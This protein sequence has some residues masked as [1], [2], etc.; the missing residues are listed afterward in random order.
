M[1]DLCFGKNY[2]GYRNE[3]VEVDV[4]EKIEDLFY[5]KD[6]INRVKKLICFFVAKV[7]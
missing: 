3:N 4:M 2:G 6:E 7:D 5:D 1:E